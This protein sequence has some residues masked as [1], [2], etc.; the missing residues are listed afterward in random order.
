MRGLEHID[1]DRVSKSW[2]K[3]KPTKICFQK[4]DNEKDERNGKVN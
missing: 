3:R 4:S 1:W 2:N